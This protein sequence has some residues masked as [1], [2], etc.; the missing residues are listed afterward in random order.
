MIGEDTADVLRR[1]LAENV[2]KVVTIGTSGEANRKI[3]GLSRRF[4]A[5]FCALGI[6]PHDADGADEGDLAFIR[7]NL[8]EPK[9]VALGECGL[10]Y[11]YERSGRKRQREVFE[12]QLQI[13]VET[14][15]PVVVHSREA[16]EDTIAVLKNFDGAKLRFVLHSFTSRENLEVFGLERDAFFSFNGIVTYKKSEGVRATLA[17]VPHNRFML[18]T[19][20]P[21]LAPQKARGRK[22]EPAFTPLTGAFV[23]ERLGFSVEETARL[24]MENVKEFYP[25]IRYED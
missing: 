17:R 23:A 3:L 5:V 21:Y 11:H 22:N 14:G 6:H 12:R 16:E 9:V 7:E 4:P 1:A 19:D 25:K 15:A 8:G 13:A 10:D 24:N 18:E 20:S 2:R